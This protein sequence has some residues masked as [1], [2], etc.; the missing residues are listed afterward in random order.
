MSLGPTGVLVS[1]TECMTNSCSWSQKPETPRMTVT[2]YPG[3][4]FQAGHDEPEALE[5]EAEGEGQQR[6]G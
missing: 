6:K 4:V 3:T 1:G 2:E 5:Q